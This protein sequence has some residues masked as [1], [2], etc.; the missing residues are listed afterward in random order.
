MHFQRIHYPLQLPPLQIGRSS[1]AEINRTH[2]LTRQIPPP[3][4]NLPLNRVQISLFQFQRSHRIKTAIKTL[5]PA[6]RHVYIYSHDMSFTVN[7][8][9]NNI[10][11]HAQP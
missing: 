7:L 6:K 2:I 10:Y 3:Q 11:S 8:Q 9:N 5:T 4:R 1:P